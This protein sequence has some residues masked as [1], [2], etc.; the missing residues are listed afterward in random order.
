MGKYSIT[1][2]SLLS[3]LAIGCATSDDLATVGRTTIDTGLVAAS[4]VGFGS[5][6][7]ENCELAKPDVRDECI[8]RNS[9]IKAARESAN[10][11]L[12]KASVEVTESSATSTLKIGVVR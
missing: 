11:P 9:E 6:T 7:P 3:L 1:L 4:A 8:R 2:M 12:P 10:Q 5:L